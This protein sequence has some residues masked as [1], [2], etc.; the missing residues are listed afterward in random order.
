MLEIDSIIEELEKEPIP[1]LLKD[2]GQPIFKDSWEAEAFAIGNIL[3]KQG[4]LTCSQWVEI[5]SQEIKE[6]QAKGDPDRGDTYYQHWLNALERLCIERGLTDWESY[7][8]E[9]KLWHRAVKNTP[10]GVPLTLENAFLSDDFDQDQDHHHNHHH[11]DH[12]SHHHHNTGDRP[13][14]KLPENMWKPVAVVKLQ[15]T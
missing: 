3:V 4:F 1:P 6:A 2:D 15:A 10:H 5:F 13:T 14:D 7:Q 12:H 8:Y 11:H 9:L